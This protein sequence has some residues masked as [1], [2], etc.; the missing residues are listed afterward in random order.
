MKRFIFMKKDVEAAVF[1]GSCAMYYFPSG[2]VAGRC[3]PGFSEGSDGKTETVFDHINTS[4]AVSD[5]P[6]TF[7]DV[8]NGSTWVNMYI[9]T[10]QTFQRIAVDFRMSWMSIIV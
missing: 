10:E 8:F 9:Q 3:L 4:V 1:K 5:K 2:P 6:I 7:S